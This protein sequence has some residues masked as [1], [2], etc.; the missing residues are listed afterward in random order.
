MTTL[1]IITIVVLLIVLLV[2]VFFVTYKY[3]SE[4]DRPGGP[5]LAVK[6]KENTVVIIQNGKKFKKLILPS[7]SYYL[8]GLGRRKK[9]VISYE[10]EIE[11]M[12]K[13]CLGDTWENHFND[14]KKLHLEKMIKTNSQKGLWGMYFIGIP[15]LTS[16]KE[17]KMN[18]MAFK[19]VDKKLECT[20][21]VENG[22]S[23]PIGSFN[24]GIL[25]TD[26]E[27][28]NNVTLN[29]PFNLM[30]R[31][32]NPYKFCY[33]S[34]DEDESLNKLWN[35]AGSAAM[36]FIKRETFHSLGEE[37]VDP[38][39]NEFINN[40]KDRFAV[41]MMEFAAEIENRLGIVV[42]GVQMFSAE[43]LDK[44]ILEASTAEYIARREA[45]ALLIIEKN[46]LEMTGL[47]VQG[48]NLK[49]DAKIRFYRGLPLSAVPI[50]VAKSL[51]SGITTYVHGKTD[52]IPNILVGGK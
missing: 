51:P 28:H 47:Q 6:P 20:N 36:H 41:Y 1:I 40:R 4:P 8:G 45:A 9:E 35:I 14:F 30:I 52:D 42:H 27:D 16:L 26:N 11:N 32:S 48:E 49:N 43:I 46:N 33:G 5:I 38:I 24:F 39:D 37:D 50:E 21:Y 23:L 25:V 17:I 13:N 34:K 31:I 18:Y 15:L 7:D 3:W 10:E 12:A 22:Y 19:I 29:L 44:R 2:L